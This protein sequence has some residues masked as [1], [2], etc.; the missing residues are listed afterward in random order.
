MNNEKSSR[1]HS[2]FPATSP[3]AAI[4]PYA[5]PLSS[6]TD[7]SQQEW[8]PQPAPS[9]TAQPTSATHLQQYTSPDFV[10][11]GDL[12]AQNPPDNST[13][14]FGQTLSAISQQFNLPQSTLNNLSTATNHYQYNKGF[15]QT[16]PAAAAAAVSILNRF[17]ALEQNSNPRNNSTNIPSYPAAMSTDPSFG[18]ASFASENQDM[19]HLT[20]FLNT[21]TSSFTPINDPAPT[22]KIG[23]VSPQELFSGHGFNSA[24]TSNTLTN[25]T[26][27][28]MGYDDSPEFDSLETSPMFGTDGIDASTNWAPL[29]NTAAPQD[30]YVP[31][32]LAKEESFDKDINSIAMSRNSSE[33]SDV[34]CGTPL[35]KRDDP[36]RP[37]M[38]ETAGVHRNR[39]T[40]KVLGPIA[41]DEGDTKA[42]KRA[43][44]TMAARKSRQKKRDVEDGLRE[45]VEKL[46][47][48]RDHWMML[49]LKFGAEMPHSP[50][51]SPP[52]R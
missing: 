23:T 12:Q 26:T 11:F 13:Q 19:A 41:V 27:P 28:S 8:L 33:Q 15:H 20:D 48:E 34:S 25:L 18:S 10:L 5:I 37:T 39:R 52:P 4:P 16:P 50:P 49:A 30:I 40:G 29:F 44:N 21:D 9:F 14:A 42:V 7:Q 36:L 51:Y 3:V 45:D 22:S 46:R 6:K 35:N 2:A 17:Y 31:A 43:K 47:A 38:S 24:P 32:E 1:S